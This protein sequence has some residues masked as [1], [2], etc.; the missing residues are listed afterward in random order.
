MN[1]DD[2]FKLVLADLHRKSTLAPEDLASRLDE[3][4]SALMKMF[5]DADIALAALKS[6]EEGGKLESLAKGRD[7]IA[8][9]LQDKGERDTERRSKLTFKSGVMRRLSDVNALIK[10]RNMA[11]SAKAASPMREQLDRIEVKL[12]RLLQE[13]EL[14]EAQ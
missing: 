12:D 2:F 10:A 7:G 3:W 5:H 1:T 8:P 11:D 6:E 13:L 4:R 14:Q 9:F